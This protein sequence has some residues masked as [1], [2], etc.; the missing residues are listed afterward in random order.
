MLL[1]EQ[2]VEKGLGEALGRECTI[3]LNHHGHQCNEG[4]SVLSKE[5][6]RR[7]KRELVTWSNS[8]RGKGRESDGTERKKKN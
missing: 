1:P 5:K 6:A 7:G 2:A 3:Q 8:G 4:R